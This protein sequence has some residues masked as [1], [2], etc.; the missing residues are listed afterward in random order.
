MPISSFDNAFAIYMSI[1]GALQGQFKGDSTAL[2]R[3]SWYDVVRLAL[4]T[5]ASPG[6][7]TTNEIRIGAANAL[8]V[9]NVKEIQAGG[10]KAPTVSGGQTTMIGSAKS[11]NVSGGQTTLVGDAMAPNV[12][13]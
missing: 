10:A 11:P 12:S 9:S 13:G 7:G 6:G 3:A 2:N 5:A 8:N 4:P 1:K